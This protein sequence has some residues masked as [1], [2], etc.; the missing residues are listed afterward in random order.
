MSIIANIRLTR[1]LGIH[2]DQRAGATPLALRRFTLIYGFN[3]CGKTTLSRAF[4]SLAQGQRDALLPHDCTFQVEFDDQTTLGFPDDPGGCE[5]NLLVFNADY[6][7]A[8]LQWTEGRAKPVYFIGSDQVDAAKD[9]AALEAQIADDRTEL[10]YQTKAA[11]TAE[12]SFTMFK[13][14]RAKEI[15]ARLHRVGRKYEANHFAADVDVFT[16][17]DVPLSEDALREAE[18]TRRRTAPP[19]RLVPIALDL[20]R[21]RAAHDFIV[22]LSAQSL[23][24][25]SL[26]QARS[27]P[28]MLHWL[29][30]GHAFHQAHPSSP[31]LYCG[32][33][34]SPERSAELS[35]ALDSRL[36]QFFD[37]LNQTPARLDGLVAM[38]RESQRGLPTSDALIP[39]QR[40]GFAA[41]KDALMQRIDTVLHHLAQL[42]T[43]LDAKI[44]QPAS[45]I[46]PVNLPTKEDYQSVVDDLNDGLV[47]LNETIGAHNRIVDDFARHTDQADLGIRR[48]YAALHRSAFFTHKK[49]HDDATAYVTQTQARLDR[50]TTQAED[51]RQK[52]RSHG[53][54]ATAINALV[55]AYLGHRE[56]TLRATD[57]GYQLLR[58]G[59][60]ITGPPSEGE[61]TAIA[62]SYFLSSL[63]ADNRK[64]ENTIMVIDDPVSSLDSRALNYACALILKTLAKARQLV[65]LTHNLACMNEFRKA[66]SYRARETDNDRKPKTPTAALLFIEVAT[67]PETGKR[68]AR[69]VPMPALLRNH[70]SEYHFLFDRLNRFSRPDAGLDGDLYLMPNIMRRVLEVFLAFKRPG[71][72]RLSAK[73]DQICD[74]H[75]DLD[76]TQ[77]VA[78]ERLVQLESHSDN[79]DDLTSFSSMTIEETRQAAVALLDMMT[80]VDAGHVDRLIKLCASTNAA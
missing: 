41:A 67:Q 21:L 2:A 57:D 45:P 1:G 53:P 78:V 40:S 73:M 69:L 54:A 59:Q 11:A 34:I 51:L 39:E 63:K 22:T 25:L 75:P 9:L 56:L 30:D 35:A 58:H 5:P 62:M 23:A 64:L 13:R 7:S 68:S 15:A 37:R 18:E 55:A 71:P 72:D 46:M 28:E 10:S 4:S 66:C 52:I 70:D 38:L 24:R 19:P 17:D 43:L 65:V 79:L 60:S 76:R 74:E 6:I 44:R 3:G 16:D 42:G 29:K 77:L 8:N 12:K 27:H 32:N 61:K 20:P 33:P 36:D 14:D 47:T 80:T 26:D 49:A 31:C 48:H 50:L